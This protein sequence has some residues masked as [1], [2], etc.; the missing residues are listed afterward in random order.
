MTTAYYYTTKRGNLIET[1]D[2]KGYVTLE[3]EKGE[4][5]YEYQFSTM[6]VKLQ[7]IKLQAY[8]AKYNIEFK[9]KVGA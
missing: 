8:L 2:T 9:V 3:T 6:G 4:H 5:I 1:F 7:E